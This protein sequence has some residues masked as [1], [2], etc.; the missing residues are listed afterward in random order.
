MDI[1]G[2]VVF[3]QNKSLFDLMEEGHVFTTSLFHYLFQH[4]TYLLI[5]CFC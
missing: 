4:A 2:I 5:Q 1:Y 3:N